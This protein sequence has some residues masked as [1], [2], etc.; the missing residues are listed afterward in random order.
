MVALNNIFIEFVS[1]L[2]IFTYNFFSFFKFRKNTNTEHSIFKMNVAP[3]DLTVAR[4]SPGLPSN[5]KQATMTSAS[6]QGQETEPGQMIK[7]RRRRC[8]DEGWREMKTI[9]M[10]EGGGAK[11]Y[12]YDAPT[13]C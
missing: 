9:N 6:Y 7:D 3:S 12:R 1:V 11:K 2:N 13:S 10:L 5:Q 8:T 4:V